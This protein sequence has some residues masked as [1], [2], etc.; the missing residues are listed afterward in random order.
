M[1]RWACFVAAWFV[2]VGPVVA[3]EHMIVSGGPA[4]NYFERN[5]EERHD[6][7]WGN[8]IDSASARIRQIQAELAPGE[9]ITWHVFRPAYE[10]RGREERMNYIFLVEERARELGVRMF[11]FTTR[12]D[13]FFYMN[14]GKDRSKHKISRWE[15]FGHSNK[16][17]LMF[18]YSNLLDGAALEPMIV[19]VSHL[20]EL[21]PAVFHPGAICQSWGCHSGEEFS[22]AWFA[23]FGVPMIGAIGKTDYSRGGIPFIST[24][25]GR[26]YP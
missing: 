2:G 7:Y 17:T 18:D 3:M 19:H 13:L 26:W 24:P 16:R 8:F 9:V 10:T 15:Y 21:D 22:D 12:H 20:A 11:W 23:R 5:K 14:R 4:L 6:R 25:G 1:S